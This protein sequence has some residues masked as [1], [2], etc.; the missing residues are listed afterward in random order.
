MKRSLL[1]I[2]LL[3]IAIGLHQNSY[4]T[5]AGV[6]GEG[7]Y[8]DTGFTVNIFVDIDADVEGTMRS[9][10]VKL[11]YPTAKLTNP[12]ARNNFVDWYMGLPGNSY[13]YGPPD[14]STTGEIVFTLGKLDENYPTAG[15]EG[16]RI[17][18]GTV[19]FDRKPGTALPLAQEFELREGRSAPFDDFVT[20]TRKQLDDFITYAPLS[21]QSADMIYL[22]GVIRTLQVVADQQTDVVVRPA[23]FDTNDDGRV[24]T[25]EAINLLMEIAQ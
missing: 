22:V 17:M 24:G 1:T 15:V 4:A 16:K 19:H 5:S 9:A 18:L 11:K 8:S 25:E 6:Y 14:T 13:P 2:S 12:T 23:E 10:G 7:G 3:L 20:V 21:I